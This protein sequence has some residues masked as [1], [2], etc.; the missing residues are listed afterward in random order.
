LPALQ[1]DDARPEDVDSESEDHCADETR[2]ACLSRPFVRDA[3]KPVVKDSWADA[4]ARAARETE[5]AGWR[6]S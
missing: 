3:A 6:I 5:P 2:Y 1:H 4:F